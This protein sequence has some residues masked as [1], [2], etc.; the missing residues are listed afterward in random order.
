[1]LHHHQVGIQQVQALEMQRGFP[2]YAESIGEEHIPDGGN[3]SVL[4]LAYQ[5]EMLKLCTIFLPEISGIPL[6][7]FDTDLSFRQ[8][9]I[10]VKNN[11]YEASLC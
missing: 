6:Y 1:M 4:W 7:M 5:H 11:C 2:A 10:S 3:L 9:N 8:Q